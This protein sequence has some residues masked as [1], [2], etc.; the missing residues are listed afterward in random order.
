MRSSAGR[1]LLNIIALLG[2]T[3]ASAWIALQVF[4]YWGS[5]PTASRTPSPIRIT[6]A[7]YG[8]NCR[9]FRVAP[10]QANSVQEGNVTESIAKICE[11]AVGDC[12]FVVDVAQLRDPAPGCS[13]DLSISWHCGADEAVRR[14]Y[15]GK[16]AHGKSVSIVCPPP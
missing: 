15:V 1:I 6:E 5:L 9:G 16:E 2:V 8:M 11:K 7:T 13:K 14:V 12:N 4:E 10:G 3:L